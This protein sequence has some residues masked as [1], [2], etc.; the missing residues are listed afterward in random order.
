MLSLQILQSMVIQ[1]KRGTRKNNVLFFYAMYKLLLSLKYEG[2]SESICKVLIS[3]SQFAPMLNAC[4]TWLFSYSVPLVSST[5]L[6]CLP[7]APKKSSM[8]WFFVD[9]RFQRCINSSQTI[10]TVWWKCYATAGYVHV[11]WNVQTG[12]TSVTNEC[13]GHLSTSNEGNT[14]QIRVLILNN[15]WVGVY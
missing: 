15:R 9:W 5:W 3:F 6:L 12:R 2:T 7:H 1:R 11:D 13:S 8:Q 10:S 4:T 14:D